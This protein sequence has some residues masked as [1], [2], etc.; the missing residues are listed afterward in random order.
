MSDISGIIRESLCSFF[1]A[2][3]WDTGNLHVELK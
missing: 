2:I 3:F 1:T